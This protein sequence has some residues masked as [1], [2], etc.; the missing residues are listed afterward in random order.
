MTTIKFG[1]SGWR[2]IIADELTFQN[3][4]VVSR[5]ISEYVREEGLEKKGVI[6]GRDCRFLGDRFARASAEAL[7]GNGVKVLFSPEDVPTPVI[8]YAIIRGQA[9][10]A[11]NI[12]A[13]HN[14]PEY[15]GIKFSPAWGGPA[16][17]EVTSKIEVLANDILARADAVEL[18]EES[19]AKK[20]GLWENVDLKDDY[21]AGLAE[22][23]DFQ[24]IKKSGVKP[25]FDAL[26]GAGLGYVDRA[27]SDHGIGYEILHDWYDPSFGGGAPDPSEKNLSELSKL[28]RSKKDIG[29]GISTDGDADRFGVVDGDGTFIEPNYIIALLLDYLIAQRGFEGGVARSV[30]TTHLVDAVAKHYDVPCYE[31]PVGF[32]Y[33]GSYIAEEKIAGGGEE[34]AGFTIRGHV[35]EKDGIITCLLALEMVAKSGRS[36][37]ELLKDLYKRVGEYHTM[38]INLT[39]TR[40]L[41]DA[42]PRKMEN[43]PEKFA[44]IPVAERITIDGNKFVLDDGSWILLRKS[45]TEPVVRIYAEAPDESRLK[46]IVDAARSFIES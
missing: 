22:K 39:L 23:V 19:E 15:S 43:P 30:A 20:R 38:R 27:L 29:L 44:D 33:I 11:I 24:A 7:A 36:I 35:P 31:T 17:P 46:T 2:G 45:G 14:P 5:A 21:L 1:T 8:S 12:T 40:E 42:F 25:A 9:A 41:E 10:G 4:R 16:T 6:V 32:K 37:Q 18:L 3:V 28:V 13:S 34:S 26:Y